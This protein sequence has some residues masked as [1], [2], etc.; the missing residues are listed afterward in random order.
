MN[1]FWGGEED[2]PIAKPPPLFIFAILRFKRENRFARFA[3]SETRKISGRQKR[4]AKNFKAAPKKMAKIHKGLLVPYQS[5]RQ[6]P[7][8]LQRDI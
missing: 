4:K 7:T 6:G 1:A 3:I 8:P 5:L 2:C